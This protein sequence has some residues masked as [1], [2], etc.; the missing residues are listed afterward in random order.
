MKRK[1][2]IVD[3]EKDIAELLADHFESLEYQIVVAFSGDQAFDIYQT[4]QPFDIILTDVK[5]PGKLDG[6]QLISEINKKGLPPPVCVIMSGHADSIPEKYKEEA[7]YHLIAKPFTTTQI[8]QLI[9]RAFKDVGR[10]DS[11]PIRAPRY[12]AKLP[13]KLDLSGESISC[14]TENISQFGAF[15]ILNTELPKINTNFE[16]IIDENA[17]RTFKAECVIR[18]LRYEKED[19]F[20]AGIGCEFTEIE[21]SNLANLNFLLNEISVQKH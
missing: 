14:Y 21:D 20:P 9:D 2:L 18:W 8:A 10:I 5:M 19:C 6:F 11:K 16:I 1:I 7:V 17:E 15:L 12:S 3:D 4:N 13:A